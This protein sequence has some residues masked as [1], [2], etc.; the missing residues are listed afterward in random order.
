MELLCGIWICPCSSPLPGTVVV[1]VLKKAAN[2]LSVA[3]W[4]LF[5]RPYSQRG[6]CSNLSESYQKTDKALPLFCP[7]QNSFIV[8]KQQAFHKKIVRQTNNPQPPGAKH[9]SWG[10]YWK[11]MEE[12]PGRELFVKLRHSKALL[13]TGNLHTPTLGQ[14]TCSEKTW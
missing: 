8:E 9:Y 3:L 2:I 12:K 14:D 7:V 13:C 1:V 6:V 4:S 11:A 10:I 5:H